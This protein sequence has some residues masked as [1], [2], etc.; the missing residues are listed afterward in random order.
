MK[1]WIAAVCLVFGWVGAAWAG[2]DGMDL[3][4]F[5]PSEKNGFIQQLAQENEKRL[6]KALPIAEKIAASLGDRFAGGWTDYDAQGR[7]YLVVAVVGEPVNLKKFG[8][9]DGEIVQVSVQFSEAYLKNILKLFSE[10]IGDGVRSSWIDY[11]INQVVL[12][13]EESRK[14]DLAA[15]LISKGVDAEAFVVDDLLI[16]YSYALQ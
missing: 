4:R 1:E 15:Y 14:A 2:G 16:V 9:E 7:G 13:V 10:W 6:E 3:D 5:M 11:K 12:G 8:V